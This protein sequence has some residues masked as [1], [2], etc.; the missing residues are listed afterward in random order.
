MTNSRNNKNGSIYEQYVP[1]TMYMIC[2]IVV[3]VVVVWLDSAHIL[4]DYFTCICEATVVFMS[5]IDA[6]AS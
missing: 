6:W 5:I 3:F 4:Q 2:V 1:K